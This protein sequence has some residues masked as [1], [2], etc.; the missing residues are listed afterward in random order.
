M[1]KTLEE[2]L[3]TGLAKGAKTLRQIHFRTVDGAEYSRP[4][5]SQAYCGDIHFAVAG[6]GTAWA[7]LKDC[8]NVAEIWI[9]D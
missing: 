7:Y 6:T 2:I 1:V 8:F 5:K 4:R 9:V 3:N